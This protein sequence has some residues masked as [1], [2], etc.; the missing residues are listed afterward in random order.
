MSGLLNLCLVVEAGE[1]WKE[2][3]G[4][5]GRQSF[6]LNSGHGDNDSTF[7]SRASQTSQKQKVLTETV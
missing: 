3:P 6:G 5:D 1:R 7:M 2:K 4:G